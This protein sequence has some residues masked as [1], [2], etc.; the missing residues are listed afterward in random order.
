MLVHGMDSWRSLTVSILYHIVAML[1]SALLLDFRTC[2]SLGIEMIP[3]PA[4][5]HP[6]ALSR[7]LLL[8]PQAPVQIGASPLNVQVS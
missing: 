1:I 5:E 6:V 3:N 4:S 7:Y 8:S 2:K